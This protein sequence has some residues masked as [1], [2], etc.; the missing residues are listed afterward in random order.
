MSHIQQNC[1]FLLFWCI[2]GEIHRELLFLYQ[3]VN[4]SKKSTG[5]PKNLFF[6]TCLKNG[7]SCGNVG[8][9]NQMFLI[10]PVKWVNINKN[11]FSPQSEPHT[12][13]PCFSVVLKHFGGN[14]HR[15]SLF[16]PKSEYNR[17][18]HRNTLKICFS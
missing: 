1:A 6:L 17:N 4:I 8:F 14:S 10:K 16:S 18:K 3:K 13:K 7:K 12:A 15:T 11:C 2:F 5:L 9:F